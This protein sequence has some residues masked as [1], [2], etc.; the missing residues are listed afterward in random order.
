MN[1]YP[2][3]RWVGLVFKF[4]FVDQEANQDATPYSSSQ[5]TSSQIW[6]T[7]DENQEIDCAYTTCEH[8]RWGLGRGFVPLPDNISGHHTGWVASPLSKNDCTFSSNPYLE[9]WFSG[10]HSSIGFTLTFEKATGAHATRFL[11]ETFDASG[12]VISSKEVE[13]HS[14]TASVNLLSPNYEGV[15]FTFLETSRPYSRVRIGEVLFGVIE[16]YD[17]NSIASASLLYAVDPIAETLPAREATIRLDN[18]DQRFNLINPNGI[19]AYLQQ[20]QSFFVSMGVGSTKDNI[21]YTSMGEF[22]FAS[23]TA[24]DSSLTAQITAYDWFYWLDKGIFADTQIGS[25]TLQ[26][27]VNAIIANSGIPCEVVI[28]A[29][30]ASV[31]LARTRDEMTNREALRLA[32]QAAC[33]TAYFDRAGRLIIGPLEQHTPVDV[34]DE[35][36]MEQPAKVTMENT[37][38]TVKL[39]THDTSTDTN[40]VFVADSRS[41]HE[42]VQ[43]KAVT[44]NMVHPSRGQIVA[45]WLLSYY[46]GRVT[47]QTKERGNPATRLTDTVKVF[48][49]FNMNKSAVVISQKLTFDGGLSAESEAITLGS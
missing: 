39:T 29:D 17:E 1:A 18:S 15:R 23:A 2:D 13:N 46:Q 6:Q 40:L 19:Y 7:L 33:C 9:F 20:P 11:V 38:N 25:W 3:T 34:L 31:P 43:E 28:H 21:E 10:P 45:E 32:V 8:N 42:M 27:A 12:E 26:Q 41:T 49:Y 5:N 35:N 22:Y 36:N 47:Y 44:N 14:V 24:E 16:T 4:E 30:Y 37:A 48:D